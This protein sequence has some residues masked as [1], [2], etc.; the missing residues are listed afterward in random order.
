MEQH[1]YSVHYKLT[2]KHSWTMQNIYFIQF[3][4]KGQARSASV[5]SNNIRLSSVE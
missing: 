5:I 2:P 3:Q 4:S 1:F